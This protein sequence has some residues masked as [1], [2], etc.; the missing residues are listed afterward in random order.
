MV[1]KQEPKRTKPDKDSSR[2]DRG[3]DQLSYKGI[4][5][6]AVSMIRNEPFLFVI[7]IAALLTGLLVVTAGLGSPDLRFLVLV[8]TALAIVTIGR[9]Y[10]LEG[11]K[12]EGSSSRQAPEMVS[13]KRSWS[14]LPRRRIWNTSS[15]TA[16]SS[17]L[18]R[19]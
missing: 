2:S 15:S 18:M 19:C 8:I 3:K 6:Q 12:L 1:P 16:P 9:Y 5:A 7:G 4:V 17:A 10:I 13:G 11:A 14:T